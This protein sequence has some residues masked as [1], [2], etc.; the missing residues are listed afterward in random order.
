MNYIPSYHCLTNGI[1]VWYRNLKCASTYF[2]R[3]FVEELGWV[4]IAFKDIEWNRHRVVGHI[5]E[6]RRRW[7]KGIAEYIHNEFYNEGGAFYGADFLGL[8]EHQIRKFVTSIPW[9]DEHS[10][11]YVTALGR[12]R[13]YKIDWIPIDLPVHS[14]EFLTRSFTHGT[15]RFVPPE[16]MQ[17][18]YRHESGD[19]NRQIYELVKRLVFEHEDPVA[20]RITDFVL[21]DDIE[22]YN[23][24]ITHFNPDMLPNWQQCSWLNY[25]NR[26]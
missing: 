25:V 23:S 2:D 10:M 17:Q 19:R 20:R 15:G 24:V 21:H 3:F 11:P 1:Y 16:R 9:L 7:A 4:P 8:P 6:P 18:Y 13:A 22:L 12:E 5:M 26:A 14:A